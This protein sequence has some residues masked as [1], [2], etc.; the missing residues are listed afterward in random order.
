MDAK[1]G[2]S[3]S[4]PPAGRLY[5]RTFH[6]PP[7]ASPPTR[8]NGV[9][10]PAVLTILAGVILTILAVLMVLGALRILGTADDAVLLGL[11]LVFLLLSLLLLAAGIGLWNARPWAWWL[12]VVVLVLYLLTR[13]GDAAVARQIGP[14]ILIGFIL[15][16]LILVYLLSVRGRFPPSA[17]S[18]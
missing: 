7:V 10:I 12:A 9:A 2:R 5:P 6:S 1:R 15:P 8:P 11:A 18:P 3:F 4:P 17:T 13:I 16:L 14:A